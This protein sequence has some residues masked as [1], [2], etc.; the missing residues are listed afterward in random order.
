MRQLSLSAFF[1]GADEE[2]ASAEP[3]EVWDLFCG[4]GGFSEG[5]KQA[6]CRV[7][8]ACDSDNDALNAHKRNH[9]DAVH[10]RCTLPAQLPLPTD[11]RRFHLHGSPPCQRFS[12]ASG[13]QGQ[14][15]AGLEHAMRLVEWYLETALASQATSWSMEQVAAPAVVQI[16]HR[17]ARSNRVHMAWGVFRLDALGVPQTRRRLIA[18]SPAIIARLR[19]LES[20][21]AARSVRDV[22]PRCRGTHI[23]NSKSWTSR[24]PNNDARS[25][26]KYSYN[27][28][29]WSDWCHSVDGL[30]PTVL[31]HRSLTWVTLQEATKKVTHSPLTL[32]EHACLQTFPKWYRLPRNKVLGLRLVGNSVPP[33]VAKLMLTATT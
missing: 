12:N 16:V 31:A 2:P 26:A 25:K 14:S 27:K 3:L 21:A 1:S 4:V 8:F 28:A 13:Q 15:E 9:S 33:R 5:A 32:G 22:I 30:A 19:R 6:G 20:S 29:L 11:G 17:H 23:R 7:A 18:G 24:S 10:M